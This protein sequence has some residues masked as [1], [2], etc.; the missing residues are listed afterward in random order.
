M[1]DMGEDAWD[2]DSPDPYALDW[3]IRLE[4]RAWGPQSRQRYDRT[5]EKLEMIEGKLLWSEKERIA[6]LGLLLENV[7]LKAAVRLAP[8][9][10]WRAALA[11]VEHEIR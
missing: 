10:R 2:A 4:G 3:D 8:A 11:A 1:A 5:P 6:L 9:E 7:G